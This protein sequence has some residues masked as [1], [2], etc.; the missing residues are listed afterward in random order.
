MGRCCGLD[1]RLQI[2]GLMAV[3]LVIGFLG[4]TVI[5]APRADEGS[6]YVDS[7]SADLYLNG[8]FLE[9][10]DYQVNDGRRYRMLYKDWKVPLSFNALSQPYVELLDINPPGGSLPYAKDWQGS[11]RTSTLPTICLAGPRPTLGISNTGHGEQGRYSSRISFPQGSYKVSYV[12]HIH[13]YIEKDA[14]YSH[15]N[16][17]LAR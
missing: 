1:E 2:I 17:K 6:V 11:V 7:Y 12:Y 8:T 3:A 16:L 14:R 9:K 15:L 5:E 13:P 4:Y 10:F